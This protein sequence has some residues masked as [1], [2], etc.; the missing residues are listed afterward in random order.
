MPEQLGFED[1]VI[2]KIM[3]AIDPI[4]NATAIQ[5]GRPPAS[6]TYST[7][8]QVDMATFSPYRDPETAIAVM[9]QQGMAQ[10]RKPEDLVDEIADAV[11]PK[12]RGLIEAGRPKL[13]ER[14][15]Y[16]ESLGRE[17]AKRGGWSG[18]EALDSSLEPM[19]ESEVAP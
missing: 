2:A 15:S 16:G 18:A 12:L 10:G 4:V 7:Q 17:I 1:A 5:Q 11:Y 8:E 19:G 3:S 13:D 14:I 9:L 6:A